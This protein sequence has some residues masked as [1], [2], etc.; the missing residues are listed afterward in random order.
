MYSVFLQ[1]AETQAKSRIESEKNEMEQRLTLQLSA[2]NE[3]LATLRSDMAQ[4]DI[5][6]KELEQEE[7]D[8]RGQLAGNWQMQT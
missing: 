7:K 6:V 2:L 4:S 1:S 5:R 8:L 3:N